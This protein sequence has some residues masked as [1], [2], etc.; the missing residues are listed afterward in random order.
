MKLTTEQEQVR[1][2][3]GYKLVSDLLE[4]GKLITREEFFASEDIAESIKDF[5]R[6]TEYWTHYIFW[7]DVDP[8]P[9]NEALYDKLDVRYR[10]YQEKLVIKF[11]RNGVKKPS[12]KA[13]DV[14]VL[15]AGHNRREAS[16]LCGLPGAPVIIDPQPYIELLLE[17]RGAVMDYLGDDNMRPPL[18]PYQDWCGVQA[19]VSEAIND[20]EVNKNDWQDKTTP[21]Y[22]RIAE[23]VE[24]FPLKMREYIMMNKVFFG[25][26]HTPRKT[27]GNVVAGNTYWVPPRN[28]DDPRGNLWTDFIESKKNIETLYKLQMKDWKAEQDAQESQ[29]NEHHMKILGVKGKLTDKHKNFYKNLLNQI[30]RHL[31]AEVKY[32]IP[33]PEYG[34]TG[35]IADSYLNHPQLLSA[36]IHSLMEQYIPTCLKEEFNINLVAIKGNDHIDHESEP[37]IETNHV[38]LFLE[39]KVHSTGKSGDWSSNTAKYCIVLMIA[40]DGPTL[41][42]WYMGVGYFGKDDWYTSGGRPRIQRENV[43]NVVNK[44]LGRHLVGGITTKKNTNANSGL[45][46]SIVFK[47]LGDSYDWELKDQI[48]L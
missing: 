19:R 10:S 15:W 31:D 30:R 33:F 3:H 12:K 7:E 28:Q 48:S 38:A 21:G 47:H 1:K 23:I 29:Y 34:T 24:T 16:F 6:G 17:S 25:F 18:S 32:K 9:E 37:S 45:S 35:C 46:Y 14:A 5:Y 36:K 41:E 43:H 4:S 13:S 22:A 11:K 26:Y 20:G 44:G 42:D 40:V 39:D 8:C 2:K 27:S